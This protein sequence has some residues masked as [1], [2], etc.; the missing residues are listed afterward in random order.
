MRFVS[1]LHDSGGVPL[2]HFGEPHPHTD[3]PAFHSHPHVHGNTVHRHAHLHPSPALARAL[4]TVGAAQAFR[5]VGVGLVHGLAGSAAVALLVLST[6]GS[7]AGAVAYLLLFGVG[8]IVGMTAITAVLAVSRVIAGLPGAAGPA[9]GT[10]RLF[11]LGLY[12]AFRSTRRPLPPRGL[13]PH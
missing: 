12:L 4:Q 6:V 9:M 5:S 7:P 2:A 8:T 10:G 11:R 3:E 13:D 1:A